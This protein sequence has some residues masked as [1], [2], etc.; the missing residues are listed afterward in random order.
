MALEEIILDV[1]FITPDSS[2]TA[3]QDLSKVYSAI[4]PP[5][6]SLLLAGAVQKNGYT[7]AILDCDAERLTLEQSVSRIQDCKARLLCFVMYGQNPNSGTTSMIGA[8]KLAEAV[9]SAGI[10]T[11]ICFCGSHTQALPMEVL[12]YDAVDIILLNEGV[13]ALNNLLGSNLRDDLLFIKGI[14]HKHDGTKKLNSLK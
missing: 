4:E 6:W 5:T 12:S 8:I 9:K 14:G 11:P 7:A 3:Y 13:Y 2:L 10:S 1:L